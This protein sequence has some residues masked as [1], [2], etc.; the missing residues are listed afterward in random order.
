M[1]KKEEISDFPT[2]TIIEASS[3]LKMIWYCFQNYLVI[4]LNWPYLSSVASSANQIL[5]WCFFCTLILYCSL[6]DSQLGGIIHVANAANGKKKKPRGE[7]RERCQRRI[8]AATN[9]TTELATKCSPSLWKWK[10]SSNL[11]VSLFGG[12]P[13]CTWETSGGGWGRNH[14]LS[15]ILWSC[16]F[17]IT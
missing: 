12:N 6:Y 2:V 11:N 17:Y 9:C 3:M 16:I 5:L 13:H 1:S 8:I 4:C 7:W 15:R 14:K 10:Y